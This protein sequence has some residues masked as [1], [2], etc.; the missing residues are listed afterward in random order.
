MIDKDVTCACAERG[1]R[2]VAGIHTKIVKG[3]RSAP[4]NPSQKNKTKEPVSSRY[5]RYTQEAQDW[6]TPDGL[7]ID[8]ESIT[9][10][11]DTSN[12]TRLL[13]IINKYKF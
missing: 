13:I 6:D 8:T 3:A 12:D 5:Q 9:R 10:P 7:R 11:I 2:S 4:D 1:A